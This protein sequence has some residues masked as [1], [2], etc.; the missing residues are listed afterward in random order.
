MEKVQSDSGQELPAGRSRPGPEQNGRAD[1]QGEFGSGQ[2]CSVSSG[3]FCSSGVRGLYS[4][5]V[6][7]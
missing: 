6:L 2:L 5:V 4:D 7:F 3:L 1:N